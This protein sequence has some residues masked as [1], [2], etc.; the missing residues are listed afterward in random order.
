MY[1]KH[2]K[3]SVICKVKFPFNDSLRTKD[4]DFKLRKAVSGGIL[5]LK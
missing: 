2:S 4:W 3:K 5:T 1:I